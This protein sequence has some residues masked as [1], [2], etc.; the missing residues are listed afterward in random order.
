MTDGAT[1]LISPEALVS[2]VTLLSDFDRASNQI[3]EWQLMIAGE[4]EKPVIDG[5]E[6]TAAE[7][8]EQSQQLKDHLAGNAGKIAEAFA[9]INPTRADALRSAAAQ[10]PSGSDALRRTL[11]QF[12]DQE[13]TMLRARIAPA[14][15]DT[16]RLLG[17][18]AARFA[19]TAADAVT[20]LRGTEPTSTTTVSQ[21]TADQIKTE[22][23]RIIQAAQ[24]FVSPAGGLVVY[25]TGT[26][27]TDQTPIKVEAKTLARA[28]ANLERAKLRWV[29]RT[30]DE[31]ITL[32]GLHFDALLS[33]EIKAPAELRELVVEL[34]S[35]S[36]D[37]ADG[38][39]DALVRE[40]M[41]N[42]LLRSPL[43][44][45][46]NLT[47]VEPATIPEALRRTE[48]TAGATVDVEEEGIRADISRGSVEDLVTEASR[49]L[50]NFPDVASRLAAAKP[51]I[52]GP[53]AR[54][55]MFAI[56]QVYQTALTIGKKSEQASYL[57]VAE[58]QGTLP[59]GF[60][61]EG[62]TRAV[63]VE[64]PKSALTRM[65]VEFADPL[66]S[67]LESERFTDDLAATPSND[68]ANYPFRDELD[69]LRRSHTS[70]GFAV[71]HIEDLVRTNPD[72]ARAALLRF[73]LAT[74]LQRELGLLQDAGICG[75]NPLPHH[76]EKLLG[77]GKYQEAE[78]L[79]DY[80]KQWAHHWIDQIEAVDNL[81]I[82]L[83]T[84]GDS[85][86]R[87]RFKAFAVELLQRG[88]QAALDKLLKRVGN[89]VE[90]KR[91]TIAGRMN[92]LG[93]RIHGILA[94]FNNA[95]RAMGAIND[96]N[97]LAI[98]ATKMPSLAE[99]LRDTRVR[100]DFGGTDTLRS[101]RI[102][103]PGDTGVPALG[104]SSS[105]GLLPAGTN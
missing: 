80:A 66:G 83:T 103:L 71:G 3:Y 40:G 82:D 32:F 13:V 11:R 22:H 78:A 20:A 60:L 75:L 59:A 89:A 21:L 1:V 15:M 29:G 23:D 93:G 19:P 68:N 58:Q 96:D 52:F 92:A 48:A 45:I 99:L 84:I 10:L 94:A 76:L 91:T 105:R 63:I 12:T 85:K 74:T 38:Y 86:A 81:E 100:G 77:E 31:H 79:L 72:G 67:Y 43:A 87:I 5:R 49:L 42:E 26:D 17:A 88:D 8:Q 95:F 35:L 41:V 47:E 101:L 34:I 51:D 50:Q 55:R 73:Q 30:L 54:Q 65:P 61:T 97:A 33:G 69:A 57:A 37:F 90:G 7:L 39:L 2:S 102:R 9:G 4:K 56:A 104:S 62:T 24:K 36:V 64:M 53:E 46:P 25:K 6:M 27:A 28:R 16:T 14:G 70:F 44:Y 98:E 18:S